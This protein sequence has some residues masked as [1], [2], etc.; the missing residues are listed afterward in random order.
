MTYSPI[1]F[2][3]STPKGACLRIDCHKQ[4]T[5]RKKYCSERCSK[6]TRNRR[7]YDTPNGRQKKRVAASRYF[8]VH[9]SELYEKR[10]V[11]FER[12]L[13]RYLPDAYRF[14]EMMG[15]RRN[16]LPGSE[17]K[18][19]AAREQVRFHHDHHPNPFDQDRWGRNEWERRHPELFTGK[20]GR[21]VELRSE[22][23]PVAINNVT[24][25]VGSLGQDLA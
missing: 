12:L 25:T 24:V 5:G 23:H 17:Y 2:I 14:G 11:R 9:R 7:Y 8:Q 20:G 15:C 6:L 22:F 18:R 21:T 4:V 13:T 3:K 16:G 10:R 19:S 1:S